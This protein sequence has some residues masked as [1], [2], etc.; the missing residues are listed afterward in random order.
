MKTY[1]CSIPRTDPFSEG[2]VKD[3]F[4][5]LGLALGEINPIL[6]PE[7]FLFTLR[8]WGQRYCFDMPKPGSVPQTRSSD[9]PFNFQH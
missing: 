7:Q 5:A 9:W 4:I 2:Q 6:N 3:N 8:P 1:D